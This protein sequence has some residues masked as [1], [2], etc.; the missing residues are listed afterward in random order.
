MRG[1]IFR[2]PCWCPVLI[3]SFPQTTHTKIS[4]DPEMRRSS[5]NKAGGCA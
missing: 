2:R 1:Q 4:D 5:E 3:F